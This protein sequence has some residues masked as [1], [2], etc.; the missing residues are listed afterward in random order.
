VNSEKVVFSFFIVLSLTLN[1]GFVYGEIDNPQHH[2]VYE[3]FAVIVVN[4]IA[5]ILK[6]GDRTQLG[7]V[8]LS[9]SLVAVLQLIVAAILWAIV[10]YVTDAGMTPSAMAVIVALSAGALLANVISVILLLIETVM[11][12]R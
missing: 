6:F 8:L 4:L 3:F 11:L 10:V 1:F 5:T 7:A 12:R 9:T 2:P